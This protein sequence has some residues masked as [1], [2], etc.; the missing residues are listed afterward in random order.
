MQFAS[1]DVQIGAEVIHRGPLWQVRTATVRGV[2]AHARSLVDPTHPD[3]PPLEA[4]LL[5][6]AERLAKVQHPAI[7]RILG[8]WRSPLGEMHLLTEVAPGRGLDEIV[9]VCQQKYGY[10]AA[11]QWDGVTRAIVLQVGG[12][13][14]AAH[15]AGLVH[16]ALTPDQV[17]VD[18]DAMGTL[19]VRVLGIGLPLPEAPVRWR[20]TELLLGERPSAA[21][22]VYALGALVYF[23]LTGTAPWAGDD[24]Q[25]VLAA[26]SV[27]L[28]QAQDERGRAAWQLLSRWPVVAAAIKHA[29]LP[30]PVQRP[31]RP[32]DL[33]SELGLGAALPPPPQPG[34]LDWSV[35]VAAVSGLITAMVLGLPADDSVLT[36]RL[37]DR[38]PVS[39]CMDELTPLASK[40]CAKVA[41]SQPGCLQALT[42]LAG[43]EECPNRSKILRTCLQE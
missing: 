30:Q 39:T 34:R 5:A 37:L 42:A 43:R 3:R 14:Q 36:R 6:G 24:V 22:D 28:D 27:P 11:R 4:G 32:A 17:R 35:L 10:Q 1:T 38:T 40:V 8:V 2:A 18:V 23:L 41:P 19:Q 20:P 7:P 16:A 33:L 29:L 21:T 26:R 15:D 25:A 31:L 9:R 13:L 12:A